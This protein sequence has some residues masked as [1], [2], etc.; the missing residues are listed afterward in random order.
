M[1]FY[2][3]QHKPSKGYL[4]MTYLSNGRHIIIRRGFTHFEPSKTE[5]PRLFHKE[6]AARAALREWLKGMYTVE[7]GYD[8]YT[9]YE[10]VHTKT[11]PVP[12]RNAKDMAVVKIR[13]RAS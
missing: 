12:S 13:L 4:P 5:V 2:A 9:G 7:Q 6:K 1:I 11:T 8:S 10:S 3:I